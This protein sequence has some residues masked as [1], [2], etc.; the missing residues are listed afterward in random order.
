MGFKRREMNPMVIQLLSFAR[1]P[2]TFGPLPS[3]H[4]WLSRLR[5]SEEEEE[6]ENASGNKALLA[7]VLAQKSAPT[8]GST[9]G[10]KMKLLQQRG[11]KRTLTPEE[12]EEA[13]D[14]LGENWMDQRPLGGESVARGWGCLVIE[15]PI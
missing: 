4:A 2:L 7:K 6:E 10:K 13:I 12:S 1:L 8:R 5:M 15:A 11:K 9:L 3:F 14:Y